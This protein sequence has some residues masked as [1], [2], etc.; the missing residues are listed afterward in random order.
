MIDGPIFKLIINH[1]ADLHTIVDN[2]HFRPMIR[3]FIPLFIL[4]SQLT[5]AQSEDFRYDNFVYMPHIKS[6][7]LHHLGLPTSDPI[8]DL[9]SAGQLILT[10]DDILGGDLTYNYK[11]IHCDKD[12]NRTDMDELEY[13]DG[14]NDEDIDT[15]SYSNTTVSDYTRYELL[16]PNDNMDFILSGNY[17]L[18]VYEDDTDLPVLTRRLVFVESL[19]TVNP[20]IRRSISALQLKTHHQL[21]FTI[22]NENFRIQNPQRDVYVTILQNGRWDNAI[23]NRQPVFSRGNDISFNA[24]DYFIFPASREFRFADARSLQY[25]GAGVHSVDRHPDRID[26]LLQLDRSRNER[27]TFDYR[28]INGKFVIENADDSNDFLTS[29][30]VDVHFTLQDLNPDLNKDV[31]VVGGFSD[32]KC[33]GENR[34]E[35][36]S[37]HQSYI[38]NI[39]LKQG[40]YDYQ[41]ATRDQDGKVDYEVYEGNSFETINEYIFL[42]Y[43]RPFGA[44]YDQVIGATVETSAF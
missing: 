30:Y 36:S 19:V 3:W 29:E 37:N 33:L 14:F 13:V 40:F 43:Y 5:F 44:R 24:A 18:L 28:D 1:P 32:W 39:H 41:Y 38:G 42:V 34:L 2:A 26:M 21:E 6:V 4:L 31:Y 35:Y 8:I 20:L 23:T 15:W 25:P 22:N 16:I 27:S 10:F 9:N 17:I 7:Q 11:L 12:W